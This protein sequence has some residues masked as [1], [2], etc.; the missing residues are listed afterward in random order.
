MKSLHVLIIAFVG[1]DA[2]PIPE[3]NIG[4]R[5]MQTMGW[6][7]GTGLGPNGNGVAEPIKALWRPKGVGLGF[8]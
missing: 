1:E 7:P 2:H 8:C 5:M 4:S 3:T 6:I